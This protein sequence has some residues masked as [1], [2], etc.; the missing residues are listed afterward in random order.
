MNLLERESEL[1]EIVRHLDAVGAGGG[2]VLL[3]EGPGGIG[4]TQLLLAAR[5]EA[6]ARGMTVAA[7]RGVELEREFAFG[8][9]RQLLDPI[10]GGGPDPGLFEGA[11]ALAE[12]VFAAE[13]AAPESGERSF[14]VLHG[15]YWL[16]A[17]LA[18]RSPLLLAVDD[19][20]WS[21]V[22]SLDFLSYL[23]RRVT[24]LPIAL[25]VASR[26]GE[27][28]SAEAALD[29]LRSDPATAVLRPLPL[30]GAAIGE[31]VAANTGREP[32]GAFVDACRGVTEG[33]PFLVRELVREIEERGIEP[34]ADAVGRVGELGPRGIARR[35]LARLRRV[36]PAAVDVARGAAVL[37]LDAH[38][39]HVA[40]L[41]GIA[42]DEAAAVADTLAGAGVLSDTRPLEFAHPIVRAAIYADIPAGERARLHAQAARLLEAEGAP[43][44]RVA[45][46]L[47]AAE[48]GGDP[49]TV[50]RLGAVA[51]EALARGA[52]ASAIS[53]LRRALAEPPAPDERPALLAELGAAESLIGDE[54]AIAH[55]Q[56]ALDRSADPVIARSAA[57]AL[58]R[59][60]VLTG[61]PGRAAAIFDRAPGRAGG[62]DL[63]LEGAA[64][65]AAVGDVES[66][67]AAA[68][69]V[70]SLRRRADGDAPP[71]VYAALAIAD[72][73]ANAPADRVV[74]L[75][76]K[77]TV[78]P[79][80]RGL[81]WVTSLVAVFSALVFAEA[82]D[83]AEE[84]V[85]EGL[86]V[87]RARG[88]AAHFAVCSAMRGVLAYRRGR[89]AEAEADARAALETAPRQA[90]GF[91]GLFAVATL[92]ESL[93][94]QARPDEADEVLRRIG[95]P[96][97]ATS[98]TYGALLHARGRL[99]LAQG[100]PAAALDDFL[101]SGRHILSADAQTPSTAPWRSSAALAQL[102]LGRPEAGRELVMEEVERARS[103]GG[104]RALG[105]A[106]ATAGLVDDDVALLEEAV[107]VLAGSQAAL[108][109]ARALTDLGAAL[110][111]KGRRAD[112]RDHLRR[113]LDIAHRCGGEAVA[114]RART[115]LLATGARPRNVALSG[116]ESLTASERRVTEMAARGL[117][118]REIAQALFVTQRTV[119]THLTHA[120]QKLGLDSRTE[121]A[122]ALSE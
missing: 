88:S 118:N 105:I 8:V 24:E 48:P 11:A 36:S 27:E 96:E 43:G 38:V 58:A 63:R 5:G 74:A 82:Y 56:E 69:R 71:S 52:P 67:A 35:L 37:G 44:E 15:L 49:A 31:L 109:H 104:A 25:I 97:H 95:V 103:F 23:S 64:V 114:D 20:H 98:A 47:L 28:A 119:E 45:S 41:A 80:R 68:E 46:H 22:A 54:R 30:G 61:H 113:G 108:E 50:E 17:N 122:A 7:A 76:R 60:L 6:E 14:T 55:L 115:E 91:Y 72:A 84:A 34:A 92:V 85:E 117:T 29:D 4:K 70:A 99:S 77:A 40:A 16:V 100:D 89:L 107:T 75:A 2:R 112:A 90:H 10:V 102:A 121:L 66:A 94:E 79:A 39:R 53:Y 111:R 62:W 19:A 73:Q 1:G 81:G 21:D 13:R 120:F 9:V 106:L 87:A 18:E 57:L 32:D 93:V 65:A 110:R 116:P 42:L 86:E 12:T 3:I 33:N 26:P 51:R 78:S 83:E 59:L 101:A